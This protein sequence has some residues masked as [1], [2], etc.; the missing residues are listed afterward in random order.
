MSVHTESDTA[1]YV[2]AYVRNVNR[3]YACIYIQ[4]IS[5]KRRQTCVFM[6]IM[7][8]SVYNYLLC[9]YAH[10]LSMC[11]ACGTVYAC[12]C[13]CHKNKLQDRNSGTQVHGCTVRINIYLTLDYNRILLLARHLVPILW[14][15]PSTRFAVTKKDR[16]AEDKKKMEE[17]AWEKEND[18]YRAKQNKIEEKKTLN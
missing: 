6:I 7:F 5:K 13:V 3:Q 1:V 17:G 18:V 2:Y 15:L 4:I 12:V 14:A 8:R 11:K 9:A 10:V 16:K